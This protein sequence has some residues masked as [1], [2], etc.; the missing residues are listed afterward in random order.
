M[1][2]TD[3]HQWWIE[4]AR[5]DYIGI[6]LNIYKKVDSMSRKNTKFALRKCMNFSVL[7]KLD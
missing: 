7:E 6:V 4:F 5:P 3:Y 1:E 2:P